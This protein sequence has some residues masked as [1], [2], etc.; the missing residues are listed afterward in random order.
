MNVAQASP[1]SLSRLPLA[2][3]GIELVDRRVETAQVADALQ[4]HSLIDLTEVDELR[5]VLQRILSHGKWQIASN[6]SA[7]QRTRSS[8]W[9]SNTCK[10]NEHHAV[11]LTI[12]MFS[13]A[14]EIASKVQIGLIRG[15]LI[16]RG[17]TW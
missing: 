14:N 6:A 1:L 7:K 4:R 2:G 10:T 8:P 11:D 5:E 16:P 9:I 3:F 13:M 12:G 17:Q 15:R